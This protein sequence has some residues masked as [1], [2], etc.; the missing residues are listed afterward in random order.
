MSDALEQLAAQADSQAAP[1]ASEPGQLA[2]GAE[3]QPGN[4]EAIAFLLSAFREVCGAMLKVQSLARTLDEPNVE[5]V[6]RA[7]APVADKHGLVLGD[8]LGGPEALAVMTA[9]P[10]LWTAWR[11]L[12]AELRARRAAGPPKA[13]PEPASTAPATGAADAP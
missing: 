9:G 6:A 7:L 3:P 4:F 1:P 12:D 5:K 10:V 11:E 8:W 2:P 13:E